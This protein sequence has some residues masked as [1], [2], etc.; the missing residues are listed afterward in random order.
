[1]SASEIHRLCLC[2]LQAQGSEARYF[3]RLRCLGC[4]G[5]LP[6]LAIVI[7]LALMAAPG[8]FGR[9]NPRYFKTGC[10]D[11]S[12]RRRL[13][14]A[15]TPNDASILLAHN[16]L[17]VYISVATV[18]RLMTMQTT[19]SNTAEQRKRMVAERDRLTHLRCQVRDSSYVG[20]AMSAKVPR[21]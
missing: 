14:V 17:T 13:D 10:R 4:D 7:V 2:T 18:L 11:G 6:S 16:T 9:L 12:C 1:M 21:H 20:R 8:L 5:L 3:F 15:L 19:K